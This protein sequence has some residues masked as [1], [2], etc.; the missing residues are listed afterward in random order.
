VEEVCAAAE[1]RLAALVD[2][3]DGDT[4]TNLSVLAAKYSM[5]SL[6]GKL[7]VKI[8]AMAIKELNCS[9]SAKLDGLEAAG[10]EEKM[11]ILR[12]LADLAVNHNVPSLQPVVAVKIDAILVNDENFGGLVALADSSQLMEPLRKL[13]AR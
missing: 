11:A 5:D 7:S 6:G 4:L 9:V 12:G 2:L 8:K 1:Q 13:L 10:V 3:V